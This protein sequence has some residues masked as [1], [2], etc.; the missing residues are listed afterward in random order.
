MLEYESKRQSGRVAIKIDN[1]EN[2]TN[3]F[4]QSEDSKYTKFIY[5][6]LIPLCSLFDIH[7][8]FGMDEAYLSKH[9][10]VSNDHDFRFSL[11]M[12]SSDDAI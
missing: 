1:I 6:V 8:V 7:V 5:F 2:I 3:T 10:S 4:K 12:G 9:Q 11:D